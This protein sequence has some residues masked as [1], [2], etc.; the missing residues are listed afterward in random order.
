MRAG[1]GV[2]SASR[3]RAGTAVA[4]RAGATEVDVVRHP[5]VTR[6]LKAYAAKEPEL[7]DLGNGRSR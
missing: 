4:R 1:A 3:L 7:F 2:V 6:V 5:L